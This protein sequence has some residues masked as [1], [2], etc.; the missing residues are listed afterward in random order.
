MSDISH[1]EPKDFMIS[2]VG[3]TINGD[4]DFVNQSQLYGWSG[5]GSSSHPFQI[6]NLTI[7]SGYI[8]PAISVWNTRVHF[9]ISQCTLVRG[10]AGIHLVNV[11]NAVLASNTIGEISLY[12]IEIEQCGPIQ[13]IDNQ[14][15]RCQSGINIDL[16]PE[17][18]IADN[19]IANCT[20]DGLKIDYS[21]NC[22]I[23]GNTFYNNHRSGILTASHNLEISSNNFI[24]NAYGYLQV[25]LAYGDCI[26]KNNFYSDW[27]SPNADGDDFIDLPYHIYGV[28]ELYDLKPHAKAF[29]NP[30]LHVVSSPFITSPNMSHYSTNLYGMFLISWRPSC[31]TFG[32]DVRYSVA[33]KEEGGSFITITHLTLRTN[34]TIDLDE[35]DQNSCVFRV[36]A[37]SENKHSLASTSLEINVVPHVIEPPRVNN[38]YGTGRFGEIIEIIWRNC[39]DS[40]GHQVSYDLYYSPDNGVNWISIVSDLPWTD[41]TWTSY[42]WNVTSLTPKWGYIVLVTAKCD[43]GATSSDTTDGAFSL[44]PHTMTLPY[45][46]TPIL[47]YTYDEAITINW[48]DVFDSWNHTVTYSVHYSEDA[49]VT[50][51]LIVA[52]LL[53]SEYV[54]DIRNMSEG[55]Q[56]MIKIVALEVAGMSTE[57][58]S[59][60][61]VISHESGIPEVEDNLIVPI[62]IGSGILGCIVVF[63][64]YTR[65][66]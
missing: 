59:K 43:H 28:P 49:G 65:P 33:I 50:W 52:E 27:T 24:D 60:I 25:N 38:P 12:G 7:T 58:T 46:Q 34:Y 54:W 30:Q 45:I 61:F 39:E 48:V 53:E 23:N 29:L 63:W 37:Y 9:V 5:D 26:L 4:G 21:D 17:C 19:T 2:D 13:I 22:T 55:S 57:I 66:K 44:I 14:L 62:L 18:D 6:E 51:N 16:S 40:Y 20:Y 41:T 31:D 56:Y 11:T 3:F 64:I 1:L 36:I 15:Y 47:N 35:L 42:T 10:F 8:A 32:Q